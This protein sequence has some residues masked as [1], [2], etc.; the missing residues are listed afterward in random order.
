VTDLEIIRDAVY[1]TDSY[2]NQTSAA[3][4]AAITAPYR[5]KKLS[6][7]QL[8]QQVQAAGG[9]D[10]QEFRAFW[11]Y[12]EYVCRAEEAFAAG[13]LADVQALLLMCPIAFTAATQTALQ[14]VI[15]ANTLRLVDVVAA[16][17]GSDPAPT[18][19]TAADVDAALKR[20]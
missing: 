14:T 7:L 16:E 9:G 10:A 4:A 8:I 15:A 20:K 13:D 2:H 5:L 18:T 6:L 12:Q 11:Q 1:K 17:T 3:L 19:V